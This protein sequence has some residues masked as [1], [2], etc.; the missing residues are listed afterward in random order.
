MRIFGQVFLVIL[1]TP[2]LCSDM[3]AHLYNVRDFGAQGNKKDKDTKAVQ[4]AIER[5]YKAGGGIVYFP[6]GDYLSGQIR[7][8]NNVTLQLD[9]GANLLTSKDPNDY[10]PD[11]RRLI[12]ADDA[13]NIA[14]TGQGIIT[15]I[16]QEELDRRPGIRQKRPS[17]R[18]GVIHFK[19]CRKITIRDIKILFS[20]SWAVHLSRCEDVVV[21]GVTILNNYY[22]VNSDGIDLVSCKNVRISNCYIVAGDDCI[23]PKTE[24]GPCRNVTVTNCILESN[25]TAIKLGT[26]SYHDFRDICFSNCV[27]K[28]SEA[29]IGVYAKDGG[30]IERVTFSNISI[31]MQTTEGA[32]GGSAIYPIFIDIEKR[33][34]D[35]RISKVRDINF[36]NIQIRSGAGILIQGMPESQIENL[37]LQNIS[38]RVD[39]P[40]DYSSRKKRIGGDRTTKDDRDTLYARKPSYMT[41]AHINGLTVD[42]FRLWTTEQ[43]SNNF[44]RSALQGYEIT[45]GLIRSVFRNTAAG[46]DKLPVILLH[47]CQQM[48]ITD[49]LAVPGVSKFIDLTGPKTKNIH[50]NK[51]AIL[52]DTPDIPENRN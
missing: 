8:L 31:D 13:E 45:N 51:N 33:N 11:N 32:S 12:I 43:D 6:P 10:L 5:C 23:C 48:L 49:C 37:T 19:D 34:P 14:I 9:S 16:G 30:T 1:I 15:G 7:L 52:Y 36:N 20:D 2:F 25:A 26:G 22:R 4:S 42:N 3:H 40:L 18:V 41:L 28:N 27:I 39:C 21:D 47:N 44:E 35:S 50:F 24:D 46:K 38:M 29:G 17:F